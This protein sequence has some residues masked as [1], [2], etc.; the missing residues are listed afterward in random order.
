MVWVMGNMPGVGV[1]VGEGDGVNMMVFVGVG[2]A[3]LV[4]TSVGE[5]VVLGVSGIS[6]VGSVSGSGETA[7]EFTCEAIT[8]VSVGW[9]VG[10]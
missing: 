5:G 9:M 7:T 10:S 1:I 8:A 2:G 3:V 4:G 6:V